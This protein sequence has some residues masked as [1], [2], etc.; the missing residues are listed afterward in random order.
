[1]RDKKFEEALKA[2]A[3]LLVSKDDRAAEAAHW[4]CQIVI[5]Q[6]KPADAI[7]IARKALEWG[8]KTPSA[9]LLKMDLADGLSASTDGKAEARTLYEQIAVE[10]SDDPIASRAT[11]N[12]A[13]AALSVGALADAQ[14]WS[15]AFAKRFPNDALASDV[16]YI[17]AEST[18]QL[19]QY[20]SAAT[21]F[22]Q[23]I[24]S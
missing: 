12:A 23:L 3:P 18:L 9:V 13:F 6:S 2:F 19:G 21:A 17:R 10:N 22:E 16:A 11:Y 7:P 4:M 14:R 15:E 8:N 20:E 24:T 1:M 5:V